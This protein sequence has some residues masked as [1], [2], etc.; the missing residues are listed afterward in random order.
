MAITV[1]KFILLI[2]GSYFIGNIS[3][4]RILAK[5]QKDDITKHGSGNP[6]SMNM[7]RNHG[8][9]LGFTT[10]LLDAVKGAV[11][12]LI[13]F[14]MFGW[15]DGGMLART[16]LY[17]GGFCA[18]IGHDF[19][20]VYKFKGGKGI[21]TSFGLF[22]VAEPLP[23]FIMFVILMALFLITK[24]STISSLLFITSFTVYI[25]VTHFTI[26][27]ITIL[28]LLYIIL[29]FSFWAHRSNIKRIVKGNENKAD[30][31]DIAEKD[32][33]LI[34]KIKHRG[35]NKEENK[36]N[37]N[38]ENLTEKKIANENNDAG[39]NTSVEEAQS[40]NKQKISNKKK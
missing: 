9:I 1:L 29:I 40:S 35:N 25:T 34:Q 28:I 23:T 10:L 24:I 5:K 12:A 15:V 14:W 16:A 4:A 39:L 36:N 27:Y 11:P 2:V 18:V 13:G 38:E 17:V 20:V 7:M 26:D 32:K 30:F 8:A 37:N 19:P 22:M 31:K 21:A 6:G 3:F 33:T